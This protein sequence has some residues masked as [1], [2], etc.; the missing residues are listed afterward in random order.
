[1]AGEF[2]TSSEAIGMGEAGS[3]NSETASF[4]PTASRVRASDPAIDGSGAMAAALVE[5]GVWTQDQADEALAR[6]AL[7]EATPTGALAPHVVATRDATELQG[8]LISAG[9]DK[10]T[11]QF[12]GQMFKQAALNPMTPEARA[13]AGADAERHLRATWGEHFGTMLAAAQR[14]MQELAR[15]YPKLP[16]LLDATGLGNHPFLIRRLAES[17]V[18]KA[19]ARRLGTR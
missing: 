6:P 19:V 14:E 13:Q 16:E 10:T 12:V 17:A 15:G 11:A 9:V 8:S 3:R 18:Q 7:G 2:T 1:M 4:L 5:K